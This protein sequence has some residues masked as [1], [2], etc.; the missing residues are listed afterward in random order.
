MFTQDVTVPGRAATDEPIDQTPD[1]VGG[2]LVDP[3]TTEPVE[4]MV[5]KPL[6]I[7]VDCALRVAA[8]TV[9]DADTRLEMLEPLDGEIVERRRERPMPA[10]APIPVDAQRLE[11]THRVRLGRSLERHALLAAIGP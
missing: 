3:A 8:P 4:H 2:E 1:V 5:A 11:L 10:L 7:Q 9:T 6:P